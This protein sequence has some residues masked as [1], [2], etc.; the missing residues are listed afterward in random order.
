MR[1]NDIKQLHTTE[2]TELEKKL[3]ELSKQ[4]D[5]TRME[6][7][8]GKLKNTQTLRGLRR[9]IARVKTVLKNK[10]NVQ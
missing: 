4:L 2:V 6:H 8:L 3:L 9:D 7:M 5:A 1:T 10:E